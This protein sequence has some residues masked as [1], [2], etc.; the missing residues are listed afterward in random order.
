MRYKKI[1]QT[2][3]LFKSAESILKRCDNIN[4]KTN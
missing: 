4:Q 3:I 1:V 2:Y